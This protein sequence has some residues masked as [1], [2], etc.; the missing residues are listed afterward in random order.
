[1]INSAFATNGMVPHGFGTKSKGLGGAGVAKPF[2][3][4]S[5]A[6]N[7]AS[8]VWTKNNTTFGISLF[9]PRREATDYNQASGA[10][11]GFV[12]PGSYESE[13]DYFLVPFGAAN[14]M[15][16]SES[17]ITLA[18][19]GAGGM[20]T[21]YASGVWN[22]SQQ[23]RTGIDLKQLFIAPTYSRKIGE[24]SSWGVSAVIGVQAFKAKGLAVFGGFSTDST[25]L[26]DNGTDI[27]YGLGAKFGFQTEV[28]PGLDVAIAYSTKVDMQEFDD[29]RGLF[30]NGGDLDYP[31]ILTVGLAW[32]AT[33]RSV[34]VFDIQQIYY[35]EVESINNSI[36]Q[37][38]NCPTAPFSGSDQNSC[39]GG[40]NG[41]GFGWDDMTVYKL[42]YQ[43]QHG[44]DWTWRVGISYGKNPV[45]QTTLSIL[46]P[47]VIE[48]HLTFGFTKK[49]GKNSEFNLAAMYAPESS[50]RRTSAVGFADDVELK[51]SQYELELGWSKR[52]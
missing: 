46:A 24:K 37:L 38:N 36:T 33:P 52:F 39:F 29:Y 19:Y 32:K 42:G 13:S 5:V 50:I 47:G 27:A 34:V 21:D 22:G 12:A 15:L 10:M 18:I 51:M 2:D 14:W 48:T 3:A 11:G 31:P 49:T 40:S 20:N 1:M 8:G 23:T 4:M 17:A 41:P 30:A 26:T 35:S 45:K 28:L 43:W 7:P 6:T 9:S 25:A 16:D 44:R